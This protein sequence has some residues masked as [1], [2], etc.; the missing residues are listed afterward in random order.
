MTRVVKSEL[1][2]SPVL[3]RTSVDPP[4]GSFSLGNRDRDVLIESISN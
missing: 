1:A 3:V 2:L 4:R